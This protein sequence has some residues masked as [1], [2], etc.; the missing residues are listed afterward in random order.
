M[1]PLTTLDVHEQAASPLKDELGQESDK[2]TETPDNSSPESIPP[3]EAEHHM[4]NDWLSEQLRYHAIYA[5]PIFPMFLYTLFAITYGALA[6]L[7]GRRPFIELL[8]VGS[9]L[10]LL[11]MRVQVHRR[12]DREIKEVAKSLKV[13]LDG[14]EVGAIDLK[15][16]RRATPGLTDCQTGTIFHPFPPSSEDHHQ[17][18]ISLTSYPLMRKFA[19][20]PE[21]ARIVAV[22]VFTPLWGDMLV[23]ACG[24]DDT[25]VYALP[26]RIGLEVILTLMLGNMFVLF[27]FVVEYEYDRIT[28]G[29]NQSSM[30]QESMEWNSLLWI[31]EH[32]GW[33]GVLVMEQTL[34]RDRMEDLMAA[35]RERE[36][37]YVDDRSTVLQGLIDQGCSAATERE[38]FFST[39]DYDLLNDEAVYP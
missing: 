37:Q 11:G 30:V 24:I 6:S 13:A 27:T 26:V 1:L 15:W 19:S 12:L 4:I 10:F 35:M 22:C 32:M 17:S 3:M 18:P 14:K 5:P 29:P 31:Q 9:G 34:G 33:W 23:T 21:K 25:K 36:K 16:Y 2:T 8:L 20:F 39:V 38:T 7:G 28:G